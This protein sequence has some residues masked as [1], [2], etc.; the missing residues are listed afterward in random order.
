[1]LK[2]KRF[3]C[4]L[5]CGR[6]VPASSGARSTPPGEGVHNKNPSLA[7]S[8]KKNRSRFNDSASNVACKWFDPCALYGHSQT[9]PRAGY[10]WAPNP[11]TQ[12]ALHRDPLKGTPATANF[13][14][15]KFAFCGFLTTESCTSMLSIGH[16]PLAVGSK[17]AE[18]PYLHLLRV[19]G[20]C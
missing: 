16:G 12:A 3:P 5:A 4:F 9:S 20:Q 7:L 18:P 13:H 15:H 8:G 2:T 1:M 14:D 6:P 17:G 19:H 11:N 10:P